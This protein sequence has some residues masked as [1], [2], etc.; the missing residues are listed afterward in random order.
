[1]N[2]PKNATGK[3]IVYRQKMS[4][5]DVFR[6]VK[7]VAVPLAI[8]ILSLVVISQLAGFGSKLVAPLTGVM[9]C[10]GSLCCLMLPSF[11]TSILRETHMTIGIYLIT[12]LALKYIIAMMSGVS[13]EMLMEAFNQAIPVTSGT[14]IAGTLQTIM[15]LTAVSTP[16]GFIGAQ[17]RRLFQFKRKAEKE[18]FME[19]T[20]GVR[21]TDDAHLK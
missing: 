2:I 8:F 11:R 1:M 18:K 13:S 4:G 10:V 20:R 12:L 7:A 19:R 16:I 3:N 15:W 9:W 17:G 14:A 5:G 21:L 6:F